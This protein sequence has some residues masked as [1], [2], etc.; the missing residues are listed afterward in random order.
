VAA[1]R[2]V[3][4]G[5]VVPADLPTGPIA[6]W[7]TDTGKL[8]ANGDRCPHRGMRLSHGFVRGGTLSCIY[9]G[10]RFGT[11]GACQHI[12]A[13][14]D[15]VPPRSIHCGPLPVVEQGGIVW[16]AAVEPEDAPPDFPGYDA[17]RRL[18][19]LASHRALLAASGGVGVE[20]GLKVTLGQGVG[21]LLLT[22]CGRD[23]ISVIALVKAEATIEE[24][25]AASVALEALRR[26]AEATQVETA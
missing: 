14:P 15:L 22:P 8:C 9:H 21:Y 17:L 19:V 7:R 6:V 3:L 10:W 13:H 4:N 5:T 20:G 2:D 12:P 18:V 16:V 24:R 11:N 1:S 26:R 25:R 23:E